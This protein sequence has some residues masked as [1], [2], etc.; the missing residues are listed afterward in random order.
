MRSS[1]C[2][3]LPPCF[4]AAA[5]LELSCQWLFT[6]RVAPTISRNVFQNGICRSLMML[7]DGVSLD[8]LCFF[9]AG[10]S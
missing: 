8:L 1:L 5:R 4:L 7:P 2:I 10:S 9:W 3:R 6:N